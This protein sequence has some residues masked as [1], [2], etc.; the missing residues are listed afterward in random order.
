[1]QLSKNKKWYLALIVLFL[2]SLFGIG[3]IYFS[4]SYVA[5]SLMQALG[6]AF[7]ATTGE[8]NGKTAMTFLFMYLLSLFL[9]TIVL[10]ASIIMGLYIV[11]AKKPTT[12]I[13]VLVLM[14]VGSAGML[15]AYGAYNIF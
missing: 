6:Q 8:L 9:T 12:L 14:W 13:R 7:G 4:G 11:L 2:F 1:M 15:L 3:I 10:I 5:A